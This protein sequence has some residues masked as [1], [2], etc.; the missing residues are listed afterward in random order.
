MKSLIFL[1]IILLMD[2]LRSKRSRL[3]K[4]LCVARGRIFWSPENWGEKK[5]VSPQFSRH[6]NFRRHA[7]QHFARTGTPAE[8]AS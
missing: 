2:S 4:V 3:S 6:Q 1:M 8:Q 5:M 7:T